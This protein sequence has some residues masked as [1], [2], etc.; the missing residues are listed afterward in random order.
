MFIVSQQRKK[1]TPEYRREAANL[2]IESQ[3]PIAHVARE[4]GVAPGLLGKWVKDEKQRRGSSD[5]LSETD[6]RAE[7]ARLRRELAEARLDNEFLFKS[8]SLLRREATRTEKF[9]LMRQEKANYSIKR[10]ARLLKVS[11]SGYYKWAN[12]QD[13]RLSGNDD[14][15]AFYDDVDRKIHQIWSDSDRVY[16]APRITAELAERY[17]IALNRKTVAKRMRLMGIEGISPRAFVPVT[18]IQ[19]KRKSTL[20]DLVKRMFDAGE[21]N[22]VWMSD[23]T[24]LRTGEGWLYLCVIRDGHSRRVLG[25]AMDSVQDA[26]LVERAL[27]MAYT[28]RGEVADG[29]V[30]HADRGSQFTSDQIWDV[31]RDLG[32][33]QSVGRTGVCFDNAM[34][35]SFWSTLKTEFYDRQRWPTRDAARR[36]VARWI[37]VVYNR[38]RRHSALGMISPVDFEYHITQATNK[39]E[40]AA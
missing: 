11:R 6:L 7:V 38:R 20:P 27:R 28:L 22:R 37:E 21:L 19:S 16:G 4:I 17:G 30:F 5:G 9:E 35:E 33:A 29:L 1:Y 12:K 24:Y 18:T 23:I 39:K 14:R 26:S 25:W 34:A 31:C 15:A 8:D 2:V 13:Q 32:I 3:R 40:T 36:A 10:M